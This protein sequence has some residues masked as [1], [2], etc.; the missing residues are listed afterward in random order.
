MD[1]EALLYRGKWN[2]VNHM[3]SAPR[4]SRTMGLA[5]KLDEFFA[6]Y[7]LLREA[8]FGVSELCGGS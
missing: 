6:D 8:G 7:R 5:R 1:T 4:A 2:R 3:P